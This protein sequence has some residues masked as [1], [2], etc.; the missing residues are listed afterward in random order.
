MTHAA[1]AAEGTL[2]L[3]C[4][5]YDVQGFL[6][7]HSEKK[8]INI[9]DFFTHICTDI[10]SVYGP[11]QQKVHGLKQFFNLCVHTYRP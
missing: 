5:V 2:S 7:F 1:V 3:W 10:Y 6:N 11:L 9:N 4:V 8:H